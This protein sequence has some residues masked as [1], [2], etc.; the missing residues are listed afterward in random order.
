MRV[1]IENSTIG[2]QSDSFPNFDLP[3]KSPI[4][5]STIGV[6]EAVTISSDFIRIE[7][8]VIFKPPMIIPKITAIKSGF[9]KRF[10]MMFVKTSLLLLVIE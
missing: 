10:F 3:I 1:K 6:T 8:S 4:T 7:G 9:V 5:I 2:N